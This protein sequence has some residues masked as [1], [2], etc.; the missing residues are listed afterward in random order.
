MAS[1]QFS[2]LGEKIFK[3]DRNTREYADTPTQKREN[4]AHIRTWRSLFAV[5]PARLG[6]STSTTTT[7]A[8]ASFSSSSSSIAGLHD[9]NYYDLTASGSV[10]DDDDDV[11]RSA[12]TD[13]G[14]MFRAGRGGGGEG[15]GVG[16]SAASVVSN[17]T[18]NN[19]RPKP[20]RRVNAVDAIDLVGCS[21]SSLEDGDESDDMT[22]EVQSPHRQRNNGNFV[23]PYQHPFPPPPP[24]ASIGR[25]RTRGPPAPTTDDCHLVEHVNLPPRGT[26]DGA[27]VT[28]GL[29]G[30]V[31]VLKGGNTLTCE[32]D[33]ATSMTKLLEPVRGPPSHA[34]STPSCPIPYNR[35]PLHYLQD[36]N[37]SCG[38][39]NLQMLISGMMPTLSDVFP[40]GVPCIEEIQRTME[41]LWG[42][43]FDCRNA[44]HHGRSLVGK[45]TWIGTVEV[46]CVLRFSP[47]PLA[48]RSRSN[49]GTSRFSGT[50]RALR[51]NLRI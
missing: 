9:G 39:R 3:S 35:Q 48:F 21:S 22:R 7:T 32:G 36:D 4:M 43:G 34:G 44:E 49:A 1:V 45:K 25:K 13:D 19:K 26:R 31:D 8:M 16:S 37:W 5:D 27:T 2:R 29:L 20:W 40:G 28:F 12:V 24:P 6:D 23:E 11:C 33:P 17:T 18:A 10:D 46:W 50:F 42:R 30:L 41:E 38:Y 14:R 15:G 51:P 47:C